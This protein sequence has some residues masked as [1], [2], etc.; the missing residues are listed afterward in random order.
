M[1]IQIFSDVHADINKIQSP[2]EILDT[3]EKVDLFIDAGD[4]GNLLATKS[5]YQNQFWKVR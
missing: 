5:F 3:S 4:T 2:S 1:K